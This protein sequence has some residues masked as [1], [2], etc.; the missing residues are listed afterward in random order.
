[1]NKKTKSEAIGCLLAVAL[2]ALFLGGIVLVKMTWG[3]IVYGDWKC[4]IANCRIV[5]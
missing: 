1:M 2:L 4:G 3:K 5:K